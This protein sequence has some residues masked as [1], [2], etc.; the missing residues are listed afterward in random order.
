MISVPRDEA[1]FRGKS[2]IGFSERNWNRANFFHFFKTIKKT[3]TKKRHSHCLKYSQVKPIT[4]MP[5]HCFV[6]KTIYVIRCR[7][8]P[9]VL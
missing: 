1:N 2:E 5:R 3:N 8:I 6:T 9:F 4:D 7:L